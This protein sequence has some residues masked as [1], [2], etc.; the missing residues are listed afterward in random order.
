VTTIASREAPPEV[1]P[2]PAV[3]GR[4]RRWTRLILPTYTWLMIAY[5]SLPI[6]VMIVFG[7][8]VSKG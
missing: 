1:A 4:R 3:P 7:F 2:A 5:F 6:L 8:I